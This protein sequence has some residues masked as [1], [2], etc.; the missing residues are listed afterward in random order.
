MSPPSALFFCILMFMISWAIKHPSLFKTSTCDEEEA[1]TKVDHFHVK[2]CDDMENKNNSMNNSM[3]RREKWQTYQDT[4]SRAMIID[5]FRDILAS[6]EYTRVANKGYDE[7]TAICEKFQSIM[8]KEHLTMNEITTLEDLQKD[9]EYVFHSLLH[10]SS[11]SSEH[12]EII[13]GARDR[14]LDAMY[15]ILSLHLRA[16]FLSTLSS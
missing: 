1:H 16:P 4:L 2:E 15:E 7:L 14:L 12:H 10:E 6:I 11:P 13:S 3:K 8:W 5:R 9:A